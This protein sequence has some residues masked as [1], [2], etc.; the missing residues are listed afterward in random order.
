MNLFIFFPKQSQ[1]I[2]KNK[3]YIQRK[4]LLQK[5]RIRYFDN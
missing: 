2:E 4:N 3:E 5:N 1:M